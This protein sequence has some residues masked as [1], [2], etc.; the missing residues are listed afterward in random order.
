MAQ[1]TVHSGGSAPAAPTPH[2]PWYKV[3]YIQVLIAIALGILLGYLHPEWGKS[4]KWLGDAFIALI[5]YEDGEQNYIIAPNRLAPGDVI[6][7]GEKTDTKPGNAMLLGKMP[8]RVPM[9]PVLF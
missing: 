6:I 8:V 5:K 3:L 9:I 4:V 1:T 7:A 2:E